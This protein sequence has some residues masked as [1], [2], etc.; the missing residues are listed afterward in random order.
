[1][2]FFILVQLFL[3]VEI[4]SFYFKTISCRWRYFLL[5]SPVNIDNFR[6][7]CNFVTLIIFLQ[8][9]DYNVIT[10]T[11]ITKESIQNRPFEYTYLTSTAELTNTSGLLFIGLKM[12]Y[13]IKKKQLIPLRD[14]CL[15]VDHTQNVKLYQYFQA[16]LRYLKY[17]ICF[18]NLTA[19]PFVCLSK[20]NV[21]PSQTAR[22]RIS[23]HN[24]TP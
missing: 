2:D 22:V 21:A 18:S 20:Y 9:A 17:I 8:I 15:C 4:D 12:M 19:V 5:S 6:Q 11:A 14:F 16:I 7:I 24:M 10:S 1:M 13:S 3:V 23:K